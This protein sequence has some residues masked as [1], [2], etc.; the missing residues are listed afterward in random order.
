[1][2]TLHAETRDVKVNPKIIRKQGKIPAVFYGQGQESTSVSV[3]RLP[4]IKLLEQA[5]ES[6]IFSLVTPKGTFNALIHD[7][8]LDPVL[9]D[10]IHV[11]FYITAKGHKLEVDVP[12]HFV[13]TA[14]VEKEGGIVVRV[15]HEVRISALPEKLPA[16]ITV[17]LGTL[18][19]LDA[20]ITVADLDLGEGVSALVA[21]TELVAVVSRPSEEPETSTAEP[22]LASIEVEKKGKKEDE[23][24][25]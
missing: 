24:T 11:D 7:V 12:L 20:Q 10:P 15:L 1:M 16:H 17:D 25:A 6:T 4:F 9:G 21:L 5:G 13:G 23:E 8:A 22:D 2:I 18:A 3:E 14:P 19:S